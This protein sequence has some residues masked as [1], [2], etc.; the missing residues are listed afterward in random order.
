[1]STICVSLLAILLPVFGL[2]HMAAPDLTEHWMSDGRAVRWTDTL[3]PALAIPCLVWRASY[4]SLHKYL[5]Y[6]A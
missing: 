4:Q 5:H 1:M 2:W 3:L 6:T